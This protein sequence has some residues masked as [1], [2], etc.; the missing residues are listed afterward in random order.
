MSLTDQQREVLFKPLN[1]QRVA[2]LKGMS[3][4]EEWDVE[5]HLTRIFGFEGW[6]KEVSYAVAFEEFVTWVKDGQEKRGWDVGYTAKCCLTLRDPH[7]EPVAV[8]ED[9]ASGGASHQPNRADAHH[10]ALTSAVSTA[11]KRAAKSL[12]NQFGLSLYDS[13]SLKSVVGSS[14][15]YGPPP[16]REPEPTV[17]EIFPG[18][19]EINGE[20]I[21]LDPPME[22]IR[23]G[24][25]A[26]VCT[27][28]QANYAKA[29]LLGAGLT[30]SDKL[31]DWFTTN[32]VGAWPDSVRNLSKVQAARVIEL[33]K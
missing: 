13:G 22:M 24:P 4:L 21:P 9:A 1:Q 25:P 20:D 19:E 17:E 33:L 15:A 32:E 28:S 6:D 29:L 14:L 27:P 8:R 10:L 11:L 7:G 30:D 16:D 3:Y 26:N 18:T 23:V 2:N 12:G 5:A 31:V